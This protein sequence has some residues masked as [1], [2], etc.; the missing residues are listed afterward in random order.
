MHYGMYSIG[1]S[2]KRGWLFSRFGV[3][4]ISVVGSTYDGRVE[5]AYSVRWSMRKIDGSVVLSN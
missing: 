2:C 1:G 5:R 3:K 4:N